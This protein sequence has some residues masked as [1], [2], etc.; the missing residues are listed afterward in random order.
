MGITGSNPGQ[1]SQNEMRTRRVP[2]T[3][4]SIYSDMSELAESTGSINLGQGFPDWDPPAETLDVIARRIPSGGH[5]YPPVRGTSQL[6]NSISKHFARFRKIEVNPD[7]DIVVTA[8]ATEAISAALLTF[9]DQG[10]EVVTFEPWYDAYAACVQLAGGLLVGVPL[11]GDDFLLEYSALAGAI[12]ARTRVILLNNPHNPTG[13]V[14]SRAELSIIAKVAVRHD[15]I[16]IAD[17]VYEHFVFDGME[18]VSIATLPGMY[19]RTITVG[20][21]AKT[22]AATGWKIGW[23]CGPADLVADVLRIKQ[24]LS[25]STHGPLQS[26][27]ATGLELP[28]SY[29]LQLGIDMATRRD[30]LCASL[31]ESGFLFRP[32]EGTYFVMADAAPLGATNALELCERLARFVGVVAIPGHVYYRQP[33]TEIT[34]V[35]FAYCKRHTT[36]RE[37]AKRLTQ[38]PIDLAI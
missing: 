36:L 37:A 16:V 35:R 23:F 24:Y 7:T 20:S 28:D 25:F 3:L 2:G 14:F 32:P 1:E 38:I 11:H 12:T 17:E 8:G 22:F 5:Q 4:R 6:R 9:V 13:R 33:T 34:K 27:V 15:L 26:A 19:S 18:H 29:F 21:A 31:R 10:T 30:L